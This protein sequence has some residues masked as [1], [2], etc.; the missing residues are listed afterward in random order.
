MCIRDRYEYGRKYDIY[1]SVSGV[2]TSVSDV[3]KFV[4]AF[5]KFVLWIPALTVKFSG[6]P[7]A[8]LK[9]LR[10]KYALRRR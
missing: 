4:S 1:F 5:V 9:Q 2:I 10:L 3:T 8:A 7:A 6:F